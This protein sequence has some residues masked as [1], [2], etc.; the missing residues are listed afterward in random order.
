MSASIPA[1][2]AGPPVTVDPQDPLPESNWLWRRFFIFGLTAIILV[3]VYIYADSLA[4][5]AL[6]LNE[7]AIK[8]L[9]TLL[10]LCLYLIGLLVLLYLIAPSA[11]QAG[12]WLASI[13]AWKAGVSTSST[14]TAT[15]PSGA[16]AT[17]TVAAGQSAS[18][19][20]APP[21]APAAVGSAPQP[22]KQGVVPW[23]R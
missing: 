19:L 6:A 7:T 23:E 3:G 14:S 8:G 20:P 16:S 15:A 17:A 2:T 4:K 18:P 10:K 12:K 5:A 11:E 21:A 1:A 9:I 22:Y 13:S